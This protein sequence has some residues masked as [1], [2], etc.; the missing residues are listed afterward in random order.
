MR[1]RVLVVDDDPSVRLVHSRYVEM[2]GY[3]V[4]MAADGV[5]ALTKLPLGIDLVLLDLYMPNMDGFEVAQRIR[6]H[7]THNLV[8]VIIITGSDKE[9]WYP[10]ALEVGANDVLAKPINADELRLRT[11]WLMQ[12]KTS[13][14]QL[15]E[16][17]ERL[18]ETVEKAT[19]NLR[20]ALD[21]A[22]ESERRIHVAHL[23]TIS[24]LTIAAEY[25]DE[26]IAGHLL[27]VGVAA[28]FLARAVGLPSGRADT[29]RH[30]APMHD[31]G[32]I[33]IPDQILFKAAPLDEIELALVREHCR[34][35]A[36]LLAN[37]DSPVIQ[38]GA[39][40]ALRHHEHWDG[41]GYPDG[42]VGASIPI[43]ARI[44]SV[45]D[46]YDASTM[47]RPYRSARPTDE[48]LAS[49]R[50]DSGVRFDPDVLEAFLSTLPE[51]QK[52][53]EDLPA[54]AIARR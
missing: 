45:V 35:G 44:C 37:S 3:E 41:S 33:G 31:V 38:M 54:H 32:M 21:R 25:K 46:Y 15:R 34:I 27:R 47:D 16:A 28:G 18:T 6:Q 48:V 10:R 22:T 49:M 23:D 13:N 20:E 11:R 50:A 39:T 7:P 4:E 26:T 2:L 24:R 43:E 14:D 17:N 12:L 8:P 5:E 53:Q 42:L 52:L 9:A 29:I 51:L 19:A 1:Q 36:A 40:I 30:A